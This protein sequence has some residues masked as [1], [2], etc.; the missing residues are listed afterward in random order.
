MNN[1]PLKVKNSEFLG[2]T[3]YHC[4][5]G[6]IQSVLFVRHGGDEE[7][8]GH[9]VKEEPTFSLVVSIWCR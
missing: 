9:V 6:I 1:Y 2:L 3:L 5:E 7:H 4:W 8:I